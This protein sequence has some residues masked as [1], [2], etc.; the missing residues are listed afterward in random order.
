MSASM[1]PT[2]SYTYPHQQYASSRVLHPRASPHRARARE[3]ADSDFDINRRRIHSEREYYKIAQYELSP[4]YRLA[5]EHGSSMQQEENIRAEVKRALLAQKRARAKKA[6]QSAAA[7]VYGSQDQ[8]LG[9]RAPKEHKPF[10]RRRYAYRDDIE[11]S[12]VASSERRFDIGF[13]F[14]RDNTSSGKEGIITL[15]CTPPPSP[16]KKLA[17]LSRFNPFMRP[18][19]ESLSSIIDDHDSV[20]SEDGIHDE[21]PLESWRRKLRRAATVADLFSRINREAK[22]VAGAGLRI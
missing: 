2:S 4:E 10:I 20:P 22:Q 5:L 11:A 6:A 15:P 14:P 7:L 19:A 12:R 13:K 17:P 8:H 21:Q 3:L 9:D 16:S 18:R 1:V